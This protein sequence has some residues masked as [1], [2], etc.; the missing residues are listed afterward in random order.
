MDRNDVVM[1]LVTGQVLTADERRV[2][3]GFVTRAEVGAVIALLLH[4]RGRFPFDGEVMGGLLL[5]V[6]LQACV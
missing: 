1:K 3:G 2:L 4:R 5:V 6:A